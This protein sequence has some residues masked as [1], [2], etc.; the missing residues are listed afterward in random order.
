MPV[1]TK[2]SIERVSQTEF[3]DVNE[4]VMGLAFRVHSSFGRFCNEKIYQK[5][6][7]NACLSNGLPTT[8]SEME[9]NVSHKD[10]SKSYYAD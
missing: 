3:H 7:L 9:I 5:A 8:E 1:Q 4:K 10:Y 2:V 6:L